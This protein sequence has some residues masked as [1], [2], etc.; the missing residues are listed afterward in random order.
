MTDAEME[1][2]ISHLLTPRMVNL[3]MP[4]VPDERP[5]QVLGMLRQ[6]AKEAVMAVLNTSL[7]ELTGVG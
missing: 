6:L 2:A 5:A 4:F 1:F 7:D 3:D